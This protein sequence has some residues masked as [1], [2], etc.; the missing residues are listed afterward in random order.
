[1]PKFKRFKNKIIDKTSDILS[2]RKRSKS[3]KSI[4]QG[5]SDLRD[6]KLVRQAG[7]NTEPIPNDYRSELFRARARVA[8]LRGRNKNIRVTK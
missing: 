8:V 7:K 1:M 6:I 2:Y 3:K 5:E 4:A